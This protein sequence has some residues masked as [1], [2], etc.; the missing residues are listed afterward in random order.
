M[1]LKDDRIKHKFSRAGGL[2][3]IFGK[4]GRDIYISVFIIL[5]YIVLISTQSTDNNLL[6]I[7]P[8]APSF[9]I[10][11]SPLTFELAVIGIIWNSKQKVM[12][13]LAFNKKLSKHDMLAEIQ[14]YYDYP[15]IISII[16]IMAWIGFIIM[17]LLFTDEIL[18]FIESIDI[19]LFDARLIILYTFSIP[20]F[21][22]IYSA[23]NLVYTWVATNCYESL[24]IDHDNG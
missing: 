8:A 9:V 10:I 21:F 16:A 13:N 20:L 11:I 24:R 5:L 3:L 15:M 22:F 23:F 14:F 17:W 2:K 6:N 1:P 4:T 7:V 19:H 12:S 18:I